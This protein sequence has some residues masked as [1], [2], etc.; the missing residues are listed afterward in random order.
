MTPTSL[1]MNMANPPN[2]GSIISQGGFLGGVR[3][4]PRPHFLELLEVHQQII[5]AA[6]QEKD[7]IMMTNPIEE[8]LDKTMH[9][10][11]SLIADEATHRSLSSCLPPAANEESYRSPSPWPPPV[12]N[13]E[14]IR[15]PNSCDR[16]HHADRIPT[17]RPVPKNEGTESDSGDAASCSSSCSCLDDASSVSSSE[18]KV[19][20]SHEPPSTDING[21]SPLACPIY[22]TIRAFTRGM[23]PA[24]TGP[25]SVEHSGERHYE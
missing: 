15:P 4:L 13:E 20:S 19:S 8:Y 1:F 5:E 10:S 22:N 6:I 23:C 17:S 7:A 25:F 9:G 11:P 21:D 3:M 16:P 2:R 14:A 18:T 24:I 12:A